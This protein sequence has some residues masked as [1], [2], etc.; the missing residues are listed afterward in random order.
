MLPSIAIKDPA[1]IK[2]CSNGF[3]PVFKPKF[4]FIDDIAKIPDCFMIGLAFVDWGWKIS[5]YLDCKLL[6]KLRLVLGILL[7]VPKSF[8]EFVTIPIL[9]DIQTH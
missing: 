9:F 2:G 8:T 4:W 1:M 7:A 3:A 6:M 5:L